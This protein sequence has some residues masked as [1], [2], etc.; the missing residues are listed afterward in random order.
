MSLYNVELWNRGTQIFGDIHWMTSLRWRMVL[1]GVYSIDLD[2]NAA[3]FERF[4]ALINEDPNNVMKPLV[5]DIRLKRDGSYLMGC[6]VIEAPLVTSDGGDRIQVTADGFLSLLERYETKTYTQV[7]AE[8]IAWDLI[9]TTQTTKGSLGITRGVNLAN[10]AP[11]DKTYTDTR[12]PDAIINF[13]NY[14][15]KTFEFE[16]GHDRTFNTYDTMGSA[17]TDVA[18]VY[19]LKAGG[20]IDQSSGKILIQGRDFKGNRSGAQLYNRTIGKG[21]GIGD[22]TLTYTDSTTGAISQTEYFVRENIRTWNSVKD[23]NTLQE[24]TAGEVRLTKDLY[25]LPELKINGRDFFG[26]GLKLGD[27]VYVVQ[28]KHKYCKMDDFYRIIAVEG[29]VG[30]EDQEDLTVTFDNFRVKSDG[31][32][33]D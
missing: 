31:T 14:A 21:Y 11:R 25:N 23:M 27:R 5:T 20:L 2:V 8:D 18:I 9:N 19:P 22:E 26:A 6:N 24:H 30:K 13:T 10:S 1:N 3:E 7:K 12:V 17:R 16:F 4:C 33:E 29:L 15:S 28:N 32:M